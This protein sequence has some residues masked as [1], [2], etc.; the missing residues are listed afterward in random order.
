MKLISISLVLSICFLA[1]FGQEEKA[2]STYQ[3][4]ILPPYHRNVIKINPTPMLLFS[5]IRN[6]TLSYERLIKDNQSVAMQAGYLDFKGIFTDT[7]A[8][9][10]K[11][12]GNQ[13]QP[14]MNLAFDYRYYPFARNRRPAPD[15]V[16]IG[17]YMS[18][19]GFM[20]KNTF[21]ILH[22]TVDQD[23]QINGTINVVNLG[24]DLGYQFI[25]WKR[26]S[27]DLLVFGPSVNITASRGTIEGNLDEDELNKIDEELVQKIVDKFPVLGE[28]FGSDNLSFSNKQTKFGTG[29][30]YSISVGFHF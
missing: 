12:T 27:L 19:S 4:L 3:K 16:Y 1:A 29:F 10:I 26:L 15:G 9:I 23:G 5:N 17:G 8:G 25:F 24:F 7:V 28:I 14:G 11:F 22:T 18:Y 30:R 2:D 21:D 13:N 20:L 6:I